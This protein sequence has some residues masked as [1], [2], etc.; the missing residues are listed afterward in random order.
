MTVTAPPGA[1][2][3]QVVGGTGHRPHRL[4]PGCERWARAA[5]DDLV[6][7]LRNEHGTRTVV[8]GLALGFDQWLAYAALEAGLRLW[9]HVP[10]PQQADS[11]PQPQRDEYCRL[12][13]AADQVTVYGNGYRAALYHARND[14]MLTACNAMIALWDSG[15]TS[16]GTRGVVEKIRARRMPCWWLDPV[17]RTVHPQLPPAEPAGH[18]PRTGIVGTAN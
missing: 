9:A 2:E 13:A 1:A 15:S 10:F 8:S 18:R 5:L 16:G 6:V 3:M 17:T 4:P 7:R 11:W 14:G 12:L